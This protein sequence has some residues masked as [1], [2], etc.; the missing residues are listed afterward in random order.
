MKHDSAAPPVEQILAQAQ[1]H[2]QA[3]Q[4]LEALRL[5]HAVLQQQAG[6]PQASFALGTLAVQ[7]GNPRAG[8]PYFEAALSQQASVQHYWLAYLDALL[9]GG[10]REQAGLVLASARRCGVYAP[11]LEAFERA[12][13]VPLPPAPMAPPP[14]EAPQPDGSSTQRML[15]LFAD[16]HYAQAL[17]AAQALTQQYPACVLGWKFLALTLKQQGQPQA[18]LAALRQALQLAPADAEAHKQLGHALV[19]AGRANEAS[20]CFRQALYWRPEQ[21]DGYFHLGNLQLELGQLAES[22]HTLRRALEL[23]PGHAEGHNSLGV[24]LRALGRLAES[25]ACYRMAL[26]LNPQLAEAHSNLGITLSESGQAQQAMESHRRALQ[27]NPDNA[28]AHNNLGIVLRDLGQTQAAASSYLR[29]LALRADYPEALNNLG[30]ALLELDQPE[31]AET[32]FRRALAINPDFAEAHN[33]LGNRLRDSDRLEQALDSYRRALALKPDYAEAHSN[34][35]GVLM[36]LGQ[37]AQAQACLYQ[38]L[39]LAPQAAGPL[40]S[41]L[42]FLPYQARDARFAGLEPVYLRRDSLPLNDRIKINFA[43]GRAMETQGDYARAFA[44]YAEGNQLHFAQHP[45][46]ESEDQRL[47]DAMVDFYQP[48]LLRPNAGAPDAAAL[49]RIPIFI[50]GMPRSGTSLIEQIL[51][52]HPA[53]HGA[54]E[55]TLLA[56]LAR[57]ADSLLR[58]ARRPEDALPALRQ[59][60]RDYLDQVWQ[61][62]PQARYISDKLPG[63]FYYLGLI[64]LMLPQARI[65]HSMRDPMDICFSCFALLFR[66]GHEYSYQLQALGRQYLRYQTLMRH[67]SR[68]LPPG[69]MLEVRYEDTV[70]DCEREARRLLDFLDLPWNA[71]CLDF[72]HTQRT[73]STASVLQVRQP[74]YSSSVARWQ[75]FATQLEPLRAILQGA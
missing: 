51:A 56:P 75:R 63:N 14:T 52:S 10:Q 46:D 67:W 15:A 73:V 18:A 1:S 17:E 71:A 59:L 20:D 27:I 4:T 36:D 45:F 21:A 2:Q 60:G 9:Q 47:V 68:V 72:H 64:Q 58:A 39:A 22:E 61:R 37:V 50:V 6:H 19:E 13:A 44:A 40:A 16:G 30:N 29:A 66:N 8:L 32:S 7:T 24:C 25:E 57:Q 35:G 49:Q 69:R 53:L 11:A 31:A 3:G 12:L 34:L 23:R 70:A 48:G 5:Y 65:I 28:E 42:L 54:G 55:L 26:A 62:A 33:N 41:A 74:I 38:G 43:M